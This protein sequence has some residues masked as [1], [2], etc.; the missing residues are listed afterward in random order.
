MFSRERAGWE[1][2]RGGGQRRSSV[3]SQ[4][5]LLSPPSSLKDIGFSILVL[6]MSCSFDDAAFSCEDVGELVQV[7]FDPLNVDI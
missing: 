1:G 6:V 3:E 4:T 5:S 2:G 7:S